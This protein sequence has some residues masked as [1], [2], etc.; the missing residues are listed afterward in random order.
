[1]QMIPRLLAILALA[2]VI[3]AC[4]SVPKKADCCSSGSK[5]KC[6]AGDSQCH[7]HT[8]KKNAS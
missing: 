6:S 1:M 2:L 3:P 7:V 8:A 4:A 5:G